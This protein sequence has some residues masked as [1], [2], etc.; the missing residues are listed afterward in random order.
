M[1]Y[2]PLF[3][4][5]D[6]VRGGAKHTGRITHR[7]ATQQAPPL[8]PTAWVR[9]DPSL[10]QGRGPYFKSISFY[11]CWLELAVSPTLPLSQHL[12]RPDPFAGFI[13]SALYVVCVLSLVVLGTT[14]RAL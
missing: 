9:A 13:F 5:S 14:L 10:A 4:I 6:V 11:L 1:V 8:L 7:E 3:P 2:C 12:P